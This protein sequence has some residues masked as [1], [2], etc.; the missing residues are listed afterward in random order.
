MN[1]TSS[2][3]PL[4]AMPLILGGLAIAA[5]VT[6]APKDRKAA[7]PVR[8]DDGVAVE[9]YRGARSADEEEQDV[10]THSP[11][12]LVHTRS[13]P[14]EALT[15]STLIAEAR[16]SISTP[17]AD[18]K[19]D[20][21]KRTTVLDDSPTA[22]QVI[23]SLPVTD[24]QPVEEATHSSRGALDSGNLVIPGVLQSEPALEPNQPSASDYLSDLPP[25]PDSRP[26]SP[27]DCCSVIL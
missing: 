21:A 10:E 25:L 24:L 16:G 22:I 7:E 3:A 18:P 6:E 15:E 14:K 20:E 27:T 17:D 23:R 12:D 13:T 19:V 2:S 1:K 4:P 11:S 5:N 26:S 8:E 9:R